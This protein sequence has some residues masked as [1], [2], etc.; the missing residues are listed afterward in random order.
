MEMTVYRQG[1][2]VRPDGTVV[3]KGEDARPY[4]DENILFVADGLGGA[5]AIRHQQIRQ[6]LFD[7]DKLTD[8]LF[9]GVYDDYSDERFVKY[10]KDSFYELRAVKDC[11]TTNVNN[12]KKSGYFGSRVAT[13]IFLHAM[14]Y[15]KELMPETLFAELG[16]R[17]GADAKREY[18]NSL[19]KLMADKMRDEINK[20][21]KNANL[22]YE[23]SFSGLAL[24]GTTLC[25]TVFKEENDFVKAFYF[26]AGDCRPYLWNEE[27]GLCQLLHDQEGEDGAMTNYIRANGDKPFEI[28][29]DYFEFK[30]PC[31]LFNASDGCFDSAA[32][33]SPMGYEKLIL[34]KSMEAADEAE[35]GKKLE[36]FFNDNGRHDDSSTMSMKFFGYDTF[37]GYKESAQRRIKVLQDTYLCRLPDLLDHKYTTEKEE[38][39]ITETDPMLC[40]KK[41]FGEEPGIGDVIRSIYIKKKG[42][43]NNLNV[44]EIEKQKNDL[45]KRMWDA[46]SEIGDIIG[47]YFEFFL[48]WLKLHDGSEMSDSYDVSKKKDR[49]F[50]LIYSERI[51]K[52][53]IKAQIDKDAYETLERD[54]A[55]IDSAKNEIVKLNSEY[56]ETYT[57]EEITGFWDDEYRSII[58]SLIKDPDSA[59]SAGLR[60]EAEKILAVAQTG[61][62]KDNA[63]LQSELFEQ[64]ERA[65]S[66]YME[67]K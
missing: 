45:K 51:K 20:I 55:V 13:A 10:V 60:N 63:E 50:E 42:K 39:D 12:L 41:R 40:L 33:L 23:T 25:A 52:E 54:L 58:D 37:E 61:Q 27:E 14:I 26:T 57:N 48:R 53:A 22:I 1:E 17:D 29:C 31:M 19:E 34:D 56:Y 24:L 36:D 62:V 64:Y 11:Y 67:E 2:K 4:V 6:E 35:L 47:R 28:K 65:Y 49:I 18:M 21:A 38:T 30:K 46:N 8:T 16:K 5:A 44:E 59:I 7:E 32:F 3:Y 43:T 15:D 9:N 66:K